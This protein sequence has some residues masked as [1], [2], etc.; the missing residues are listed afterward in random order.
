MRETLPILYRDDWLLAVHKP[1]GLLVHRSLIDRHETR[2]AMQLVR[3]QIGQHVFPVHRLDKGCSGVLLFALDECSARRLGQA[4]ESG[5]VEKWYTAVVRGWMP[6]RG[7]IDHP[8]ARRDDGYG[9]RET[10]LDAAGCRQSPPGVRQQAA[11]TRYWR[12]SVGEIPERAEA[13]QSFPTSRYSLV[14]LQ[15]VTGRQHQ[16]RRHLKHLAHPIIGDATHGKGAHNRLFERR[17]GVRRLL[18]AC[19]SMT[20]P[21]PVDGRILRIDAPLADDMRR[22]LDG[23]GW[24][25]EWRTGEDAR[26]VTDGPTGWPSPNP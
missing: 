14:A 22:V 6:E 26:P 8:L 17:F 4:F 7:E 5:P 20:V 16:I 11:L 24:S 1:S 25:A 21:H 19:R 12:L 10:A 15:P 3:D 18:L 23:F 9:A 2:F 13:G